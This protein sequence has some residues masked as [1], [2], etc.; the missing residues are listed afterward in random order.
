MLSAAPLWAQQ[1]PTGLTARIDTWGRYYRVGEPVLVRILVENPTEKA[2]SNAQG[3]SILAGLELSQGEAAGKKPASAPVLDPST[4]PKVFAPGG[5]HLLVTDLAKLF[6]GLEKP[7]FYRL[8][9]KVD[10][11]TS[12]PVE[13]MLAHPYDEDA[14]YSATLKTD[15]G[16]ITFD[17]L[18]TVAPDHVRNFV[19][20][21]NQGY[22][23]GSLFH[24]IAKGEFIMGGSQSGEGARLIPYVLPPEISDVKHE[25]GTLSSVRSSPTGPD[26]PVQF[27]IDLDRKPEFDG[28]LSVFGKIKTGEETLKALEE[29]ATS[30]Q[31]VQPFFKPLQDVVLRGVVINEQPREDL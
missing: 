20:L 19:D 4:Q 28:N 31:N 5:G 29:V 26:N 9:L 25:R 2:I 11:I 12:D 21:A 18:E 6:P 16:D 27:I 23:D 15:H 13:L 1:E 22:Y 3:I 24:V 30:L 17:L 10:N 8:Q 14:D 7:G